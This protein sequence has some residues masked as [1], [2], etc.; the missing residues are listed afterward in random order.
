MPRIN[1]GSRFAEYGDGRFE[2]IKELT[3]IQSN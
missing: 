3:E 1:I 2:A